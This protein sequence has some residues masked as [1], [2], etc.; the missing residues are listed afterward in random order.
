MSLKKIVGKVHLWLG[1]SSGLVVFII[2][3]TGCLYAFKDE[4]Q[5]ATQ[6]FRFVEPQ[7]QAFLPPSHLADIA[8]KALPDKHLHSIK[9]NSKSKAAEAIFYHFEPTH[10]YTIFMNPYNGKVLRIKN[11][12]AGVFHFILDGHFYLWLP[13]N[14]GQPLVASATLIFLV[15]LISGLILWYPK[16]KAAAKQRVW[17]RW[18]ATTKWKRKNY[19]LHNIAGFYVC[20]LALI[21]AV[22]GLVWGFQWFAHAYYS[23]VGGEK[24]LI[25]AD[26]G[27]TKFPFE[28]ATPAL[29]I[30]QVWLT[31]Q[32]EYPS[33]KSIEVHP[34]ESDSASIAANANFSEGTYWNMDYRYFD[35]YTLEEKSVNHIYGRLQDAGFA[36]R[37]MRMNYDIH[38]GAIGGLAGKI[39]AFCISLIIA[40][41]PITGFYIWYG[42]TYK[43]KQKYTIKHPSPRVVEA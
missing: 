23:S 40:T 16:N 25:Y 7:E 24:S 1:L 13:P 42:R 34:P 19:D 5:H 28:N 9:Y 39:L 27:S 10:Y 6:P 31:M 2:A 33:A 26:P 14:I 29:A 18:K 38:V 37:V 32:K 15:M 30:D 22:T 21:F 17:F 8:Q 11:M 4:I 35:Q 36:D 41:L 43:S 12:E 3:I 20:L